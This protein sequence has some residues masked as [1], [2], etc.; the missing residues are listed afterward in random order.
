MERPKHRKS[1]IPTVS[2]GYQQIRKQRTVPK[3]A[4]HSS[5]CSDGTTEEDIVMFELARSSSRRVIGTPMKKL[6][7]EEMSKETEARRRS[8]SLIARLMG[9][10]GLPS[11]QPVHRQQKKLLGSYQERTGSVGLQR[12]GQ[13]YESRS[14]RKS[15]MEQQQ[16]KD[17][18]VDLEASHMVNRSN[19][20]K[21]NVDSNFTKSEVAF[22]QQKCMVAKHISYDEKLQGSKEFHDTLD[23]LNSSK[24]LLP[25]FLQ[26]PDY[27]FVKHLRDVQSDPSSSVCEHIAVLKPSNAAK[28][29][30]NAKGW[31]SERETCCK[32]DIRPHW[33]REDGLLM[34]TYKSHGAQN[35]V[36][37]LKVQLEGKGDT[38]VLPTRIVVLKPNLVKASN[39]IKSISS[40]KFSN[41]YLSDC[42]KHAEYSS[43][44]IGKAAS[45]KIKDLSN[46]V[47]F[48]RPKSREARELAREITRQMKE[49]FGSESTN[50]SYSGCESASESEVIVLTSRNSV[51]W[52]HLHK[53]SSSGSSE[54]SVSSEAKKRLSERWNLTHRYQDVGVVG[55]GSTLGEMLALP[56]KGMRPEN[57][58]A[59]MVL[60]GAS[61]RFT[62]SN[63][64]AGC[65]DPVGISSRDG[66]KDGCI[67]NLSRSRSLPPLPFDSGIH[68]TSARCEA[69]VDDRYQKAQK[70]LNRSR[71]KAVRGN[72]SQKED[73]SSKNSRPIRRK[74]HSSRHKYTDSAESFSA[75][76]FSQFQVEMK[77]EKQDPSE[78]QPL[79]SQTPANNGPCVSSIAEAVE[80]AEQ[81]SITM[82][83]KSSDE[84][85]SNPSTFSLGSGDS[86]A[87]DEKN[88]NLQV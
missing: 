22:M 3:L 56:D 59:I 85:L 52:N 8:P 70:A 24:D 67:R 15:S 44:G 76:H 43:I 14:N 47:A 27:L 13:L 32:H 26:Q 82:S 68:R 53:R 16:F 40:P 36:R 61:D 21:W 69:F 71:S 28:Y 58:D 51:D 6:L 57:L 18:Y 38:G 31:K 23:M 81:E 41:A 63:S 87:R 10:D 73:A 77:F 79:V 5:S 35:S 25:R 19:S 11:P 37:S 83:S 88:L 45:P 72:L 78:Q 84:F 60:D 17:V 33:I 86:S 4:S 55:R 20:S 2:E 29:E 54:S 50:F 49:S 64:G 9:L 48:S 34:D 1:K 30:G 65:D 75:A 80:D 12:N 66:W 42:R 46:D 62:S 7:A 74:S 39:G